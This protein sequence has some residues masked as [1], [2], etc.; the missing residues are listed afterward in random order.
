MDVFL[1][2]TKEVSDL[3][4]LYFAYYQILYDT[5]R[6]LADVLALAGITKEEAAVYQQMEEH[7]QAYIGRHSSGAQYAAVDGNGGYP[8]GGAALQSK[9]GADDREH[10]GIGGSA[11]GAQDLLSD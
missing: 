11:F 6:G 5:G 8:V 3:P 7:F 10:R 9:A 2:D 4:G 1:P